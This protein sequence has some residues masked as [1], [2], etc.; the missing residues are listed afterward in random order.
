MAGWLKPADSAGT[1]V[2]IM[3]KKGRRRFTGTAAQ[4]P[5]RSSPYSESGQERKRNFELPR[6]KLFAA[7]TFTLFV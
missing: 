7:A 6:V 5:L 4:Q 1:D 2:G 3:G